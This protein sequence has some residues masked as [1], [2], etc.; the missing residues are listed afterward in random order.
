MAAFP[1]KCTT[2]NFKSGNSS[3]T[4]PEHSL[5]VARARSNSLTNVLLRSYDEREAWNPSGRDWHGEG[6]A[7]VVVSKVEAAR[8]ILASVSKGR[9]LE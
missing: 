3:D 1:S 5:V 2:T 8:V 6:L 7:N 4:P 9:V